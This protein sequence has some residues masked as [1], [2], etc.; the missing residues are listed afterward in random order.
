MSLLFTSLIVLMVL[1]FLTGPLAYL[2]EAVLSAVV[3]LIGIDLIDI[4][5]MRDIFEQRR[6]WTAVRPSSRHR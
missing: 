2:P 5:G 1:L 4:K 6:S 3:F